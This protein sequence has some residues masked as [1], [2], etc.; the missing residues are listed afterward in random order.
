MIADLYLCPNC[1]FIELAEEDL[2]KCP[3]CNNPLLFVNADPEFKHLIVDVLSDHGS[4]IASTIT[5]LLA[6]TQPLYVEIQ[7]DEKTK[8]DE[9][10]LL[11]LLKEKE[12]YVAEGVRILREIFAPDNI[13][14]FEKVLSNILK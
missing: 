6:L 12:K 5:I 7:K 11:K 8:L 1:F 2:N 13:K 3:Q 14:E 4:E 9:K 10:E